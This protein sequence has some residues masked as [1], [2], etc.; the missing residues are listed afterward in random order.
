MPKKIVYTCTTANKDSVKKITNREEDISYIAILDKDT[1]TKTDPSVL[2]SYTEIIELVDKPILDWCEKTYPGKPS[3][4]IIRR[5]NILLSKF[6]KVFPEYF[7]DIADEN[8]ITLW[9]DG[10]ITIK[11]DVSISNLMDDMLGDS[12]M[13][14]F[15]H[16][17]RNC[18]FD[19]AH[20]C[21]LVK[22][23]DPHIINNQ[24]RKYIEDR[25]PKQHGLNECTIILRRNNDKTKAFN[26]MWWNEIINGSTRDQ[27]SFN[28]VA[29]KLGMKMTQIPGT[30]QDPPRHFKFTGNKWFS[31]TP[32][33]NEV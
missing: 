6:W 9:I 19:E 29:W 32:H 17:I 8:N 26:Q 27:I 25:M 21:M 16:P 12:D 10:S 1:I 15:K 7:S 24:I 30:V 3:S 5:P 13:A 22:N 20:E 18:I 2:K 28:Y 31:F 11:E 23:D 33:Y 4:E 14:L